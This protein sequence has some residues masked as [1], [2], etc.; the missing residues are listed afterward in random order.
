M[1][2]NSRIL[3]QI[4]FAS[5]AEIAVSRTW[6]PEEDQF[7]RDNLALMTDA[8]IGEQLGRS[9][10][11]VHLRWSRDLHLPARSK[12]PGIMTARGAARLLGIDEHKI[13]HWVDMGLIP[14]RLMPGKRIKFHMIHLVERVAFR[15]WVLNPMNWV[16]FKRDQVRDPELKRML[17]LRAARWGDAWWTTRQVA[18]YHGVDPK[19]VERYIK[20]RKRLHSFHLPVSL[21]GRQHNRKWSNHFVLRSEAIQVVFYKGKGKGQPCKFTPAADQWLLYARDE[22]G[23]TF[24]HIGRTMKIGTEKIGARGT[25]SNHMIGHRYRQL[26][27]AQKKTRKSKSRS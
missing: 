16:Y 12:A 25:R 26:K 20:K 21:G 27:A 22:L 1:R 18:D 11:A 6:S 5:M 14:G 3:D 23:M 15:R 7:L 10:I 19:D 2:L 4:V 9:E 13:A 24:V 8:E 17:K